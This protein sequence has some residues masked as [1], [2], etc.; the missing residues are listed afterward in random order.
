M[1]MAGAV[2][3]SGPNLPVLPVAPVPQPVYPQAISVS[4]TVEY[5]VG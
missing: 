1:A 4:V 2:S 3:G 5:R